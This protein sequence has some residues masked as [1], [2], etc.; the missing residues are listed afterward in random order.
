MGSFDHLLNWKLK[1]GSHRFPGP[2]GG[3]C[4]NEAAV[5]AAG[6]EYRPINDVRRMPDCFS[7]PICRLAMALNDQSNNEERQRLLPFVTR[8]ACADMPE[9]EHAREV[10]IDSH[11][12]HRHVGLH[13]CC[14]RI[15]SFEA[16]LR[17]LEGALAIGRQADPLGVEKAM[18]CLEEARSRV[19]VEESLPDKPFL[20]KVKGWLIMKEM[21]PSS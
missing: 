4:I 20:S 2:D 11:A 12:L 5:V 10:Y 7:R 19:R 3:T 6:F 17:V 16:G 14:V 18:A 9:V 1:V 15:M 21:E 13:S 8:L